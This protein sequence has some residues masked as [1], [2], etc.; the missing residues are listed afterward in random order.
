M[1]AHPPHRRGRRSS[2]TA[3]TRR[4]G[5]RDGEG[6]QAIVPNAEA[7]SRAVTRT[8]AAKAHYHYLPIHG[9]S[10]PSPRRPRRLVPPPAEPRRAAA[11]RLQPVV[12]LASARVR[13]VLAHRRW[14]DLEEGRATKPPAAQTVGE[15]NFQQLV[16]G[17]SS[18]HKPDAH[19]GVHRH[20]DRDRRFWIDDRDIN[21]KGAG[22]SHDVFTFASP[23]ASIAPLQLT[24]SK[25]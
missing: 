11:D 6:H 1:R 5:A 15:L 8:L 13:H 25:P 24:I 16:R 17:R 22:L 3:R 19:L 10:R 4:R 9:A 20:P 14:R 2:P 21:S 18:A 12:E 23:G 7:S